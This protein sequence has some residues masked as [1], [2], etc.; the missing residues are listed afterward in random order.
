MLKVSHTRKYHC[1]T[2]FI[3]GSNIAESRLPESEIVQIESPLNCRLLCIRYY[4]G[5]Q[6]ENNMS[7]TVHKIRL[8]QC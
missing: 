2:E 6:D 3:G 5:K 7:E 8:Q 1:N 4:S